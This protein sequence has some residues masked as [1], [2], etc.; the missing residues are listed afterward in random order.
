MPEENVLE[1]VAGEVE[2]RLDHAADA[3]KG[4]GKAAISVPGEVAELA[5][6]FIG[7]SGELVGDTFEDVVD[8]VNAKI[9]EGLAVLKSLG[10]VVTG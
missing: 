4:G 7:G 3:I 6:D 2:E 8:A 5:A 9:K 1:T 10:G